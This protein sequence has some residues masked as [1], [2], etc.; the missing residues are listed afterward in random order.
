MTNDLRPT[1]LQRYQGSLLGLACGDAVGTSVEF[2]PRGSF[3]PVTDMC[4]GGPFS[5][6]AGQWTDDTSM[7]LCLA[8]SLLTKQGFDAHD[9][10]TRYV[11]WWRWGYLSATGECFD[12]GMTVCSALQK[13]LTTGE[14]L[15]GST[16]PKSAGNG[17]LMRLVP[18]VLYYYPDLQKIQHF[19]A[20]S[21]RTTHGAPEAIQA[22]ILFASLL[23]SALAGESK[24]HLSCSSVVLSE[25]KLQAIANGNYLKKSEDQICGSGYAVDSLEAALWCFQHTDSFAQA[26]LCAANLGEDADTTAAIVGQI[27]GAHYGVQAIPQTWLARLHLR[28][29]IEATA[30]A[31][32]KAA[33]HSFNTENND[34]P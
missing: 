12:I 1:L 18:I 19:S 7:A 15:A 28:P 14:A 32:F 4:G 24:A 16:D 25:A 8:E 33:G 6:R 2:S 34:V 20:L 5:L 27:A 29:E 21:S 23:A 13:F 17:S 3:K 10:M 11:N 26:V 30:T 22:S 31:L 9:Q